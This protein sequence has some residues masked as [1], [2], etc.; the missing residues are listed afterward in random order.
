VSQ[1]GATARTWRDVTRALRVGH[2][3]WPGDVPLTLSL[4]A[5]IEAGSSVN[6]MTLHTSTH[7]GTHLD[8][9]YHYQQD[10]ARLA[11]IP[12]NDLMGP[13]VVIDLSIAGAG[14]RSEP[15]TA[16]EVE[17]ALER[18]AGAAPERVFI[19]TGQPNQWLQFPHGFAP[20]TPELVELLAGRGT[21]LIG[22]DA[23]SVDAFDSKALPVHAAFARTQ[24]WIVEGL[25]LAD[26]GE[27]RYE[28]IV[29]PLPLPDADAS[30]VRAL[31]RPDT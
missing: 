18:V 5:E 20:L 22:T 7:V 31:L 15:C 24:V 13:C 4:S 23:P 19:K 12:L 10:G 26:V 6:V 11:A 29:L 21:R 17:R 16:H 2:P 27:G 25:A 1:A 9:P 14:P 8:A 28:T 3:N 30:P